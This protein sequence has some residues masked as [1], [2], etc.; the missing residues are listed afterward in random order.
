MRRAERSLS[1]GRSAAHPAS[2]FDRSTPALAHTNPWRVSLMMR[3]PRRRRMRTDSASTIARR[4]SRSS[5]STCTRRPS[6]LETI[7]WVT[8]RQSPSSRG[9]SCAAAA[10]AISGASASSGRTS[11]TPCTGMMVSGRTDVSVRRPRR[12]CRGRAR[13]RRDAS[14]MSVSATTARTPSP[15]ISAGV[16]GVAGVDHQRAAERAVLACDPHARHV[17]AHRDP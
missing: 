3:S 8:T 1:T 10:S 6:A 2:T 16:G 15:S 7:F 13:R 4:A 11:G 17:D 5:G 14:V 9:V 12:A